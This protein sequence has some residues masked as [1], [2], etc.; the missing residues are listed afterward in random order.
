MP[1]NKIRS[2]QGESGAG[3]LMPSFTRVIEMDRNKMKQ[4]ETG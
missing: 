3:V 1:L 2:F 4:D